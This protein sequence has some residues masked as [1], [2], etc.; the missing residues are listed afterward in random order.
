MEILQY[1]AVEKFFVS[2]N[3]EHQAKVE[4]YL[5]KLKQFTYLLPMPFSKVISRNLYELRLTGKI[6]IRIFY[7]FYKG[8]IILLHG[9]IKKSQK[10]PKK[11]INLAL[12][13]KKLLTTYNL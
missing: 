12:S 8:N 1:P 3:Y 2:L 4:I 6:Q 9:F 13:R 10:I 5:Q 7:T 11:E